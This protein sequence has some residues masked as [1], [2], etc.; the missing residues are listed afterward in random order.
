MAYVTELSHFLELQR[1]CILAV[2]FCVS[3]VVCTLQ[4]GNVYYMSLVP[5]LSFWFNKSN[6]TLGNK[7]EQLMTL[8][9]SHSFDLF[10]CYFASFM[11]ASLFLSHNTYWSYA[12]NLGDLMVS[13]F[14][15]FVSIW[16]LC[17]ILLQHPA[18]AHIQLWHLCLLVYCVFTCFCILIWSGLCFCIHC[19]FCHTPGIA[20]P[21]VLFYSIFT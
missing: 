11:P 3:F 5:H 15:A 7:I 16:L 2:H 21:D 6:V 13:V 8:H 17:A 20:F 9:Y 10:L 1:I 18:A 19:I 4:L 14:Y 12:I